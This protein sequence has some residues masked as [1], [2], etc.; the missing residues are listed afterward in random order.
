MARILETE[1][2]DGVEVSGGMSEAGRGSVWTGLRTEE[3]EGYFVESAAKFK[4][5]LGIPVFGLGGNRTFDVMERFVREGR[6]D[7]IS[8]SRPLV[9]EPDLVQ[10]FRL[11]VSAKSACISCNKCFNPRGLSCGDLKEI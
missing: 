5:A 10:K 1:G 6:V 7:L 3:E 4:A 9:R 8:L 11:G 2:L